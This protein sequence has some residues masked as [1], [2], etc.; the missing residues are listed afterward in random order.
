MIVALPCLVC[1]TDIEIIKR[2]YVRTRAWPAADEKGRGRAAD[3]D[4]VSAWTRTS[5]LAAFLLAC[6]SDSPTPDTSACA[7]SREQPR[8]FGLA[9]RCALEEAGVQ[10]DTPEAKQR[11]REVVQRFLAAGITPEDVP[12]ERWK[13]L[14]R[15]LRK[16]APKPR[17]ARKTPPSTAGSTAPSGMEASGLALRTERILK[18]RLE[19]GSEAELFLAIA[20]GHIPHERAREPLIERALVREKHR[21]DVRSG[22]I[23]IGMSD[24]EVV[25]S[26]GRVAELHTVR[27]PSGIR[28]QLIYREPESVVTTEDGF[29]TSWDSGSASQS[30]P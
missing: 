14:T 21:E 29:V 26:R 20:Y 30:P 3:K 10:P 16:A 8:H 22:N 5:L 9:T 24:L 1:N 4:P 12:P 11:V 28:R 15:P 13:A 18:E 27:R 6:A 23:A 2:S 7:R 25:L 19:T 17:A